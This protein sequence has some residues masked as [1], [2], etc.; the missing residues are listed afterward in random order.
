M[1]QPTMR[2]ATMT[3]TP[4][5]KMGVLAMTKA[6]EEIRAPTSITITQ[7]QAAGLLPWPMASAWLAMVEV[8][9]FA[10]TVVLLMWNLLRMNTAYILPFIDGG[11]DIVRRQDRR[12]RLCCA[13][14]ARKTAGRPRLGLR[15]A[16]DC[17]NCRSRPLVRCRVP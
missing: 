17:P 1:A 16:K 10:D 12:R 5:M 9:W 2:P 7:V 8:A 4:P 15:R 13:I 6:M 14:P 3:T 11:R